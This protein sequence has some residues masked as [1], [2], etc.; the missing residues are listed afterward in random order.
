MHIRVPKCKKVHPA[1]IS[2]KRC[3]LSQVTPQYLSLPRHVLRSRLLLQMNIVLMN[4]C[5]K[6]CRPQMFT[7]HVQSLHIHSVR[8]FHH[9]PTGKSLVAPC[10]ITSSKEGSCC[11][12]NKTF[13]ILC[14][15]ITNAPQKPIQKTEVHHEISVA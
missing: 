14:I 2:G 1:I 15:A 7:N 11:T 9:T 3:N 5:C 10:R 8:I 13:I 4:L 12:S 6:I